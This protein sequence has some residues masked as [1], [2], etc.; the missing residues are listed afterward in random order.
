MLMNKFVLVSLMMTLAVFSIPAMANVGTNCH[1]PPPPADCIC[2]G[3]ITRTSP[4][5]LDSLMHEKFYIWQ[6]ANL[7]ELAPNQYITE[8]G[9]L[10]KGINNYYEFLDSDDTLYIHVLSYDQIGQAVDD[11]GMSPAFDDTPPYPNSKIYVGNDGS[12]SNNDKF[13]G[14]GDPLEP[15]SD[16]GGTWCYNP[17]EDVC[18]LITGDALTNLENDI[19]NDGIVGIALDS[20]CWY[21]FYTDVD[22][23]KFWYCIGER[24]NIPAP[25]AVVLGGLGV[26]LVGWL[27][28]RRTL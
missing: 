27:R 17:E 10:F 3:A 21:R 26:A 12:L 9:L 25:G 2:E 28:R 5:V 23:I 16:P 24:P 14:L 1:C 18:R 19:R 13:A 8:A 15:Y 7:P 22:K 6:I 20:D 4:D 11:L